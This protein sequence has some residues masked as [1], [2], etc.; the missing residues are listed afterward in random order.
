[1]D[2]ERSCALTR[3]K[4]QAIAAAQKMI[5][6]ESRPRT[7]SGFRFIL[8]SDT[9]EELYKFSI[10]ADLEVDPG[11][12]DDDLESIVGSLPLALIRL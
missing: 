11:S 8:D 7:A 4:G 3:G 10:L 12:A 5:T 6:S 9:G 2:S 1:M